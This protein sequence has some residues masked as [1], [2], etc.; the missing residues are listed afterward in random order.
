ME[1][2]N[3]NIPAHLDGS[4][5]RPR[6]WLRLTIENVDQFI[7]GGFVNEILHNI[8]QHP[9]QGDYGQNC[10]IIWD[11]LRAHKTPYVTHII[12]ERLSPNNFSSVDCP[13]YC[14]KI[15]PIEYNFF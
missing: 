3:P 13:P 10:I 9:V 6:K 4:L 8:E 11:N 14:P 1:A 2:G 15:T 7:F 12:E 5:Q